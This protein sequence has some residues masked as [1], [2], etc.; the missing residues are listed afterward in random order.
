M[1]SRRNRG[2]KPSNNTNRNFDSTGP[3]VKVRG[4]ASSVY[5][6]YLQYARDAQTSGDRIAS[7]N[8]LQ[9]AEHYQRI[10]A[11]QAA[12]EAAQRELREAERAEEEAAKAEA[13]E[14]ASETKAPEG[15]IKAAENGEVKA[16]PDDEA[17][18]KPQRRRRTRRKPMTEAADEVQAK[19]A[20][21]EADK[22]QDEQ[23]SKDEQAAPASLEVISEESSSTDQSDSLSA[24]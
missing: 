24:A 9:H 18:D 20:S 11:A 17:L 1:K 15:D 19:D 8:F 21:N 13:S 6:K 10:L 16:T 12:K 22:S 2:R 4:S 14:T 7:E 23:T 5:E 3:G